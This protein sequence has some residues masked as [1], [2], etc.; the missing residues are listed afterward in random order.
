MFRSRSRTSSARACQ[1]AV[2]RNLCSRVLA[3]AFLGLSHAPG[4]CTLPHLG[5]DRSMGID[6]PET[7]SRMQA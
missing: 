3:V 7:A 1:A 5:H 6:L 2:E 4:S